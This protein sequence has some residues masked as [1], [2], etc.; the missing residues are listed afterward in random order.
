MND[1]WVEHVIKET[2]LKK[3]EFIDKV[4][5]DGVDELKSDMLSLLLC[6]NYEPGTFLISERAEYPLF[7][8]DKEQ[9]LGLVSWIK[10]VVN[11]DLSDLAGCVD[12]TEINPIMAVRDIP[13]FISDL[14]LYSFD[15]GCLAEKIY[16]QEYSDIFRRIEFMII[17]GRFDKYIDIYY[18]VNKYLKDIVPYI[19][20]AFL[21][22]DENDLIL[23]AKLSVA[24]GLIG[25]NLKSKNDAAS[26]FY[27]KSEIPVFTDKS[28]RVNVELVVKN[29]WG[30]IGDTHIIDQFSE[31]VCDLLNCKN[32][33]VFTDDYMETF[34]LLKFYEMI[35]D[36]NKDIVVVI[37]PKSTLAGNDAT[38]YDVIDML[39]VGY[40][41]KMNIYAKQGRLIV[42]NDGP[43]AGGLNM[44][45][46]NL[47]LLSIIYNSDLLDI[48][49][50]RAFEMTQ[51][52]KKNVYYSFNIVREISESITGIDGESRKMVMIK[53]FSGEYCFK[54][55][56]ERYKMKKI[57]P[58]GREYMVSPFTVYDYYENKRCIKR[59]TLGHPIAK[60]EN[61]IF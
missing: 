55:F 57:A 12:F 4:L 39:N 61:N 43:N 16:N 11:N 33:V 7:V 20:N 8:S 37:V 60:K 32:I 30:I 49:G 54:G 23:W 21:S 52:I 5:F 27:K 38:Y 48:R 2:G 29:L 28:M 15:D 35:L 31:F 3:E 9:S 53:Q 47:D 50:C 36:K 24:S 6:E 17:F 34:F 22:G 13:D 51:G 46:I 59:N 26:D 19:F 56:R 58:S 44:K 41:E 10:K 40:L 18:G 42:R 25:L 14:V 45:K 1:L